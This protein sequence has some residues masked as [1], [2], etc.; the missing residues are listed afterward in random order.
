MKFV[1]GRMPGAAN[2]FGKSLS[3]RSIKS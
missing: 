2:A 1:E 3:R